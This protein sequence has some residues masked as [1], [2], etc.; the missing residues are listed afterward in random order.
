M[1]G[2]NIYW[3]IHPNRL[4]FC[5]KNMLQN[6][7]N[8]HLVR[9]SLHACSKMKIITIQGTLQDLCRV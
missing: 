3:R 6:K 2:V 5:F 7:I 4:L 1:E 8:V 9:D